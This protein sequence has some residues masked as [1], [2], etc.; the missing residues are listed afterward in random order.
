METTERTNGGNPNGCNVIALSATP[1]KMDALVA[2]V[3]APGE[4]DGATIELGIPPDLLNIDLATPVDLSYLNIGFDKAVYIPKQI[5]DREG[6]RKSLY[7]LCKGETIMAGIYVNG[8][9][10]MRRYVTRLTGD[11]Q[12]AKTGDVYMEELKSRD[13]R[14]IYQG[15]G[16]LKVTDSKKGIGQV[17]LAQTN[18]QQYSLGAKLVVKVWVLFSCINVEVEK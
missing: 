13:G 17:E 16:A 8:C 3:N 18:T 14:L 7:F 10:L 11:S 12:P 5:A 4:I 1:P 15:T 9:G 2:M 6:G